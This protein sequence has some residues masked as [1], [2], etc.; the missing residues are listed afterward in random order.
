[1]S[2]TVEFPANVTLTN[3][4]LVVAAT[5]GGMRHIAALRDGRKLAHGL[6]E[7]HEWQFHIEGVCGEIA[8]GKLTGLYWSPTVNTFKTGGDIVNDVQVRTRSQHH[9]DLIIRDDDQDEHLFFLVTGLAP[10]YTVRGWIYG[11]AGKQP[12]WYKTFNKRPKAFFVPQAN[13]TTHFNNDTH[14]KNKRKRSE[15]SCAKTAGKNAD[16]QNSTE[17]P[18]ARQPNSSSTS[19]PS[20]DPA[21]EPTLSWTIGT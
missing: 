17:P 10:H 19:T 4:E 5:T 8:V 2:N 15:E 6:E 21:E 20:A 18:C 1:M 13:L 11:N 14:R 3:P 9:Y 7:G 16:P 12:E